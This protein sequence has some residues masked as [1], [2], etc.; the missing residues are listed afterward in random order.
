M[1]LGNIHGQLVVYELDMEDKQLL[2]ELLKRTVFMNI[3][4][5]IPMYSM[6]VPQI[7]A[8]KLFQIQ[9]TEK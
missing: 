6:V 4:I 9:K 8:F 1:T 5:L 7:P 2:T 3:Y